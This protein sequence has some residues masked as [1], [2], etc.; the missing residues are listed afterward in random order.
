ML[1]D[2]HIKQLATYMLEDIP[3]SENFIKTLNKKY[4]EIYI[5]IYKQGFSDAVTECIEIFKSESYAK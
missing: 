4:W 5:E 2:K 3:D 1:T